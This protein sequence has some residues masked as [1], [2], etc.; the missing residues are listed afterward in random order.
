V[1]KI[2]KVSDVAAHPDEV[3]A[4]IQAARREADS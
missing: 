1:A 2:Y 4:D 3:L